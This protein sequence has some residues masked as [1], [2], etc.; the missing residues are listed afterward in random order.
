M[1]ASSKHPRWSYVSVRISHGDTR[2]LLFTLK[3]C[4]DPK[5]TISVHVSQNICGNT[6]E[7]IRQK[8]VCVFCRLLK[9]SCL[10]LCVYVC[11]YEFMKATAFNISVEY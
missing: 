3:Y 7:N 5:G 2:K 11:V 10:Y 1:I 6:T 8:F 9:K 4:N